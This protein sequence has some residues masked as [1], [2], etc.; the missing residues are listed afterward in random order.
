M[1]WILEPLTKMIKLLQ[2]TVKEGQSP[3]LCF[4]RGSTFCPAGGTVA[5]RDIRYVSKLPIRKLT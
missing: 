5:E 3:N 1:K 2:H 4:A